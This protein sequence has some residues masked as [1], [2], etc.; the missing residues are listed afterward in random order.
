MTD[1]SVERAFREH[2][3]FE[4]TDDGEFET[5]QKPFPGVVTVADVPGDGATAGDDEREY[6][7]EVRTP[8]LDAAVEGE[9]VAEVVEDGWFETLELRLDDAHTVANAEASPPDVEREGE[10]VVVTTALASADPE[11]AAEDA[12]AIVEYVEGTW[13]Q[14]IIPGYDYREPAASLRES[15]RQNYD[16][17]GGPGGAGGPSDAGGSGSAGGPGGRPR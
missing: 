10:E 7:L 17:G 8:T 2:P 13:V 3:D 12:L 16:E 14:G 1:E 4:Q 9:E 15:A 6:R 5:P 11:R